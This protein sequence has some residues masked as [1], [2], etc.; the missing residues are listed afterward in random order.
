VT[1]KRLLY[2][3]GAVGGMSLL[4]WLGV[5][6]ERMSPATLVLLLIL[7]IL[8]IS[9][10]WGRIESIIVSAVAALLLDLSYRPV[11]GSGLTNPQYWLAFVTFLATAVTASE[12]SLR[13]RGRAEEAERRRKDV[14]RLNV[15]GSRLLSCG[16]AEN[17]V[18]TFLEEAVAVFEA[19]GAAF[20]DFTTSTS[21]HAGPE[22]NK[23]RLEDLHRARDGNS[24]MSDAGDCI[25]PVRL[26]DTLLGAVALRSALLSL[27]TAEAAVSLLVVSLDRL[28]AIE[29]A[30]EAERL[31]RSIELRSAVLDAV[32]HDLKTPLTSIK[33]SATAMLAEKDSLDPAWADLLSVINEEADHLT[34][35]AGEALETARIQADMV[36]MSKA[37]HEVQE[38]VMGALE[39]LSFG[40]KGRTVDLDLPPKLPRVDIDLRLMR[41]AVKQVLDNAHKY[42]P[43][44]QPIHVF[45]GIDGEMVFVCVRDRGPG[46]PEEERDL[47]FQKFYRGSSVAKTVPGTGLGVSIAKR[48]VEAGGGRLELESVAGAGASFRFLLPVAQE[49]ANGKREDSRS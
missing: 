29:R 11:H 4:V 44:D 27:E 26:A 19:A 30:A 20:H 3:A 49:Q 43:I 28:R 39:D 25:V 45:A 1:R 47:I 18:H 32:A 42:S 2:L 34:R 40:S 6:E 13:A 7:V 9:T 23:I 16:T 31:R 41:Q 35:L 15:L 22:G 48:I 36:P 8:A 21:H 24:Y 37:A 12:L 17:A 5:H 10:R 38:L 14:E 46:I 33:M